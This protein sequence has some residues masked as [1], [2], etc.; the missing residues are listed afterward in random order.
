MLSFFF[1]VLCVFLSGSESV[2][3]INRFNPAIFLPEE[4]SSSCFTSGTRR[5][6]LVTN[7]VISQVNNS[8]NI[9]KDNNDLSSQLIEHKKILQQVL[10]WDRR[11]NMLVVSELWAFVDHAIVLTMFS[12]CYHSFLWYCVSF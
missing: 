7:P 12:L 9:N 8:T 4:I 3:S 1:V 11:K 5:V 6:N 2:R 10:V